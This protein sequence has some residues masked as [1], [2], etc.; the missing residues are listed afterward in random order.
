MCVLHII[1]LVYSAVYDLTTELAQ[2]GEAEEAWQHGEP[3]QLAVGSP[4]RKLR[5]RINLNC[6]SFRS[7]DHAVRCLRARAC[8]GR[9]VESIRLLAIRAEAHNLSAFPS[10]CKPLTS[11]LLSLGR[12]GTAPGEHVE[13]VLPGCRRSTTIHLSLIHI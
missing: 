11:V 6:G 1:G 10:M 12:G 5:K 8:L 13:Q 2:A 9:G 3:T 4:Y 7:C